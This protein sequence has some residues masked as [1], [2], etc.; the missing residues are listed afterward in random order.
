MKSILL[1]KNGRAYQNIYKY[2][3]RKSELEKHVQKNW[4][5]EKVGKALKHF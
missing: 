3:K 4:I 5:L 2:L 1:E